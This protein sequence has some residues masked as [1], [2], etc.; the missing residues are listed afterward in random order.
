MIF[1]ASD[2]H[3]ASDTPAARAITARFLSFLE[4][5]G[6]EASAVY[7]LG[8]IFEAWVGDEDLKRKAYQ[9]VFK[10]L[11]HLTRSGVSVYFMAG[12]RDF[13]LSDEVLKQLGIH[14]LSDPYVLSLPN[15][16][17]VL[18]H[19]DLYCTDDLAYQRYRVTVHDPK[20]QARF[21]GYPYWIRRLIARW[22][23]WRSEGRRHDAHTVSVTDV[24]EATVEDEA[25]RHGYATMI[26]GHTHRPATHDLI[27]DGI[28]VERW[29]LADWSAERG[30]Y[31]S[32]D[33]TAEDARLIRQNI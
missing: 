15:W 10:A 23:R 22:L 32:W 3:L 20:I 19:G 8:D 33:D 25:R 26:H 18:S 27:V 21:L 28:H 17:F 16:Q 9:P 7:L 6:R 30:E 29:V 11:R 5:A 12:N 1:F 14:R 31:L 4:R 2:V 24:S 13:L